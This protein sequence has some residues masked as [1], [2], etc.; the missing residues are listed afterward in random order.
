MEYMSIPSAPSPF[1]QQYHHAAFL[2]PKFDP[3]K[4]K[5][6]SQWQKIRPK[7]DYK[8]PKISPKIDSQ[9]IKL[10]LTSRALK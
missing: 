8:S 9:T 4:P 2:G 7:V 3:K 6:D 1:T 5:I 10:K